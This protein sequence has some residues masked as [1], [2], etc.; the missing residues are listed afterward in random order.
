MKRRVPRLTSDEEAEAFL[1]ADLSDLDFSQ[2]KSEGRRIASGTDRATKIEELARTKTYRLFEQAMVERR[3]I[4]C[5]YKGHRRE[6]CPVILGHRQGEERAL[7]YQF[8]GG[9]S[10]TLPPGGQWRCLT[11]SDVSEIQLRDGQWHSGNSHKQP[12]G[13]VEIVDL[14]INPDSPF[15]PKRRLARPSAAKRRKGVSESQPRKA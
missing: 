3:Q 2:F 10:S 8:A 1:D 14:D 9:S 11:L 13:C 6:I 15:S 7:T 12:S 5:M 4:I